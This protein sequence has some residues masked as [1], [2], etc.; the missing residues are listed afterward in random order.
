MN[1]FKYQKT[2]KNSE[3]EMKAFK[4]FNKVLD[5]HTSI[6]KSYTRVWK[7]AIIASSALGL[8][9]GYILINPSKNISEKETS[10]FNPSLSKSLDIQSEQQLTETIE[11]NQPIVIPPKAPD[12]RK[13]KEEINTNH[14]EKV[15]KHVE[16][17]SVE[18]NAQSKKKTQESTSIMLSAQK[19]TSQNNSWFTINEQAP[20]KDIKLPTLF[21]S[22]I[23]WPERL[24]KEELTRF[25]NI[26]A[27]Y[28]EVSRE[29]PIVDGYAY[30]TQ[31]GAKIKPK[32]HRI[33]GNNFPPSLIRAL[34][35][36]DEKSILLFKNI[37]I[38]IPGEGYTN[39]GDK[40]IT[41]DSKMISN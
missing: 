8:C 32:G 18:S 6:T 17:L 24:K 1:D 15:S 20:N 11:M 33:K 34:H 38:F 22:K 30:V 29:I 16:V 26:N 2:P 23:A 19:T 14:P 12:V 36:A 5:K 35:Q 4:D 7:L 28:R 9:I 39:I 21:V 31:E 27:I 10:L 3:E 25:P 40:Q 37:T 13:V 41:I